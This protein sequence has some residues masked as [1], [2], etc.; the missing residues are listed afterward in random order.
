MASLHVEVTMSAGVPQPVVHNLEIRLSPGYPPL[1]DCS[2]ANV[3]VNQDIRT[4]DA[5]P[6]VC[7]TTNIT[8]CL[9]G[10]RDF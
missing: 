1:P 8:D 5:M 10:H 7:D 2:F 6:D 4:S 9:G 3:Q